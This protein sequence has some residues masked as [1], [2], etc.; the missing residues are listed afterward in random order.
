VIDKRHFPFCAVPEKQERGAYHMHI[1]VVGNQDL[2]FLRACWYVA[3]GGTETDTD[4]AVRGNIDVTSSE[5]RFGGLTQAL[6]T[7]KLVNYL[8][9]YL[10]KTFDDDDT[11]G[12]HRYTKSRGIPKPKT[13]KQYLMA[14]F[15]NG[16]GDFLD[17]IKETI[18]IAKLFG[19]GHDYTLYNRD[20]DLFILR[21][22]YQ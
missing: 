13:Q 15:C 19:V 10:T 11:L 12:I 21:G 1:A 8:C 7:Q 3:L 9:K 20:E 22:T 16:K 18:G 5:M 6:I 4:S 14:C 17:A 2:P